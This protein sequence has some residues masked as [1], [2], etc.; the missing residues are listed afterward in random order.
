MNGIQMKASLHHDG[1]WCSHKNAM[2]TKSCGETLLLVLVVHLTML[3]NATQEKQCKMNGI[4][5]IWNEAILANQWLWFQ[6]QAIYKNKTHIACAR[7]MRVSIQYNTIEQQARYWYLF[8]INHSTPPPFFPHTHTQ[9]FRIMD[10]VRWI[11]SLTLSL[12]SW[13]SFV[14][15]WN[16]F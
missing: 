2:S 10:I 16:I 9:I 3:H 6:W 5:R 4:D 11:F 7:S 1:Y 15:K 14:A 13:F 12:Y 8:N